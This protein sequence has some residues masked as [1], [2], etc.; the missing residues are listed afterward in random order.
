MAAEFY[1]LKFPKMIPLEFFVTVKRNLMD[2]YNIMI[3][4]I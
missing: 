4:T 3:L 2:N 1:D